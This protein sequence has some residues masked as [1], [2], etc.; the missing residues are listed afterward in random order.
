MKDD[1]QVIGWL[2]ELS[3]DIERTVSAIAGSEAQD[4]VQEVSV[5]AVLRESEFDSYE[6]FR[7]WCFKRARWMALDELSRLRW[8][9]RDS[10]NEIDMLEATEK[11]PDANVLR[12]AIELLPAKQ[13]I[14]VNER[15]AGYLTSEIAER[16]GIQT[17]SVRSLWRHAKQNLVTHFEGEE[18]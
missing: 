10:E 8:F 17:D 16:H 11:D 5:M 14:V 12:T 13:K 4:I 18:K 9:S 6:E 3:P 1:S 7:R 2:S 15:I